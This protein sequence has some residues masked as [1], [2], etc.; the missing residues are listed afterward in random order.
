[1]SLRR[2]WCF[3]LLAVAAGLALLAG[4]ECILRLAG[5]GR[6]LRLVTAAPGHPAVLT[7]EF[8]SCVDLAYYGTTDVYG[9]EPRRFE[10]PKPPGIFRIV[11]LGESTVI[12]FPYAA[13]VAFPRQV[14]VLLQRQS[15]EVRFEVLNAGVTGINSFGVADLAHECLA[16]DPDLIVIHVGHNEFYGPGGPASTVLSLPSGLVR[17]T[18]ALRRYRTTQC[19]GSLI[20]GAVPPQRDLL[21]ALPRTFEI[22]LGSTEFRRAEQNL[23]SN[24]GRAVAA[25]RGAGVPVVLAS[26]A[27][28]LRDQGPLRTAWPVGV[29]ETRRADW[30]ALLDRAERLLIERAPQEALNVLA[31][32]ETICGEHAR[33]QYRIGQCLHALGRGAEAHE[34]FVKARDLDL[35]RFRAPSSFTRIIRE[36]ALQNGQGVEYLDVAATLD[37]I[38][39]P[40]GPGHDL[41]LEHVHYNRDGHRALGRFFAVTIQE[42]VRGRKWAAAREPTLA[43]LDELLGVVPEDELAATSFAL[44]VLQTAPLRGAVDAPRSEEEMV[45]RIAGLYRGLSS[46]RQNVFA[47]LPMVRLMTDLV[48]GL[49]ESHLLHGDVETGLELGERC[50]VRC[51]WS[52]EAHFTLARLRLKSGDFS[53]ARRSAGQAMLLRPEWEEAAGF[54]QLVDRRL[55]EHA[56]SSSAAAGVTP[57]G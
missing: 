19:L 53:G 34:A 44:Q 21:E 32:A 10:L 57:P 36:V 27:C 43:E 9:P 50:V 35:C 30:E 18:I 31:D 26:M 47:E 1:M 37:Q 22:P 15:P 54:Q 40:A 14:E 33:L 8:N 49:A 24:L 29:S 28:N 41:F 3:R 20:T 2:R 12:G 55:R 38:N 25:A 56:D 46:T 7:H 39:D 6:D 13:E 52:A 11:F 5:V 48:G 23:K 51:P 16:C 42:R 17:A 4:M 45:D